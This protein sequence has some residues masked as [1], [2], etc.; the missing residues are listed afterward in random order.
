MTKEW[1]CEI[2]RDEWWIGY[3]RS[4]VGNFTKCTMVHPYHSSTNWN[5]S[6]QQDTILWWPWFETLKACMKFA[7]HTP[8]A[9]CF[10]IHQ[11]LDAMSPYYEAA[12]IA[13]G[14]WTECFEQTGYSVFE[15]CGLDSSKYGGLQ[16]ARPPADVKGLEIFH[17]NCSRETFW[18]FFCAVP[19]WAATSRFCPLN[20]TRTRWFPLYWCRNQWR[21]EGT[22]LEWNI[23]I[24][25]RFYVE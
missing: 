3:F 22:L 15:E 11:K 5:I 9:C 25:L 19:Y 21:C 24:W 12:K 13:W 16:R 7:G 17:K 6:F 4:Q 20:R 1:R 2:S 10:G 18:G 14:L 23:N 8:L